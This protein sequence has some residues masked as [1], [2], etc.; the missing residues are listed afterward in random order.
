MTLHEKLKQ[1]AELI[2]ESYHK[3]LKDMA[4]VRAENRSEVRA[5]CRAVQFYVIES[6]AWNAA[7]GGTLGL[8]T[9]EDMAKY[10]LEMM[11][12]R[13]ADRDFEYA[14]AYYRVY[15]FLTR[16]GEDYE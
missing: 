16:N 10:P 12:V 14:E 15:K 13:T 1:R 4:T 9:V 7:V 3:A 8:Q 2:E 11:A 6:F 5:R